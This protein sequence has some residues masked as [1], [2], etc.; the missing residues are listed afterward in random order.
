LRNR[1]F[2]LL[3]ALMLCACGHY[4]LPFQPETKG[5][6]NPLLMVPDRA[7]VVVRPVDGLPPEVN[8]ALVQALTTALQKEGVIA[9]TTGGTAQSLKLSGIAWEEAEGWMVTLVLVDAQGAPM[10]SIVAHLDQ[11][12]K[13]D[14][15]KSWSGYA[16]AMAKSV[17][18]TFQVAGTDPNA[19][20]KPKVAIGEV[21]GG[22]DEETRA[23]ARSL[24]FSL[25]RTTVEIADSADA[26]THIVV[27][28]M[29]VGPP[30]GT[31]GKEVRK[32]EVHWTVLRA[33]RS[34]I[35]DLRQVNDVPAAMVEQNWPEIALA[36][37]D[38][39]AP[40][41]ANLVIR[42]PAAAR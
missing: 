21:K 40:D 12:Q 8:S 34:E 18:A 13:A 5:E 35:G 30:R 10:R 11:Q 36:V 33:D 37:A 16:G 4:S 6:G 2:V 17:A 9:M 3:I 39:A 23:L 41:V 28:E 19:V 22:S 26:A 38:A 14:D 24:S 25:K 31:A 1:L 29:A 15:P 7:G 20:A 42:A 32:I 27:G